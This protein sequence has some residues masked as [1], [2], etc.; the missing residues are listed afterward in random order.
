[1]ARRRERYQHV[2]IR[3]IRTDRQADVREVCC[4]LALKNWSCFR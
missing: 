1:V 4:K 3:Q 2:E